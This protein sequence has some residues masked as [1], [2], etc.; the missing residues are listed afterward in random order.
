MLKRSPSEML[1]ALPTTEREA[2]VTSLNEDEASSLL[3]DWRGFVARPD[4]IAPDGNWDIWLCLAG[5]GW[6]KTRTGAEWIKECVEGGAERIALI[7]ETAA[8]ARDVIVEGESGILRCYPK[9]QRPL[10]E[11][12]KRRVTWQNGATATLF[13]A[14]E[15]DQLRG[16]QFSVAWCDELAKWRYARETWDMLQFGLRLGSHPRVLVTTT[17]RP[18]EVVKAILA[19]DEGAVTVTRG[20]TMDN[21]S[22]LAKTF[23]D[24]VFKRYQGTRLGRQELN[25]EI[26]GDIPNALWSYAMIETPRVAAVPALSRI[27]VAI[28]PAV[29]DNEGSDEHGI[30][31]VGLD[32]T[33][34]EAYVL[35]DGSKKGSPLDW[36]RR[37]VALYDHYQADAIVA[38]VNQG[39]DMVTQTIHT[40]RSNVKVISVRATR[41]KH[42]RAEPIAALY[43]QGKVHHVGSFPD[44]ERQM[45]MMTS[46][47]YEGDDSPDRLDA[48]V[49][50]CTELF[51]GMV[52][53]V[54]PLPE[55]ARPI[56]NYWNQ[57]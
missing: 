46:A 22:N 40:V 55:P 29:S 9:S 16:P 18:I 56:K 37:A 54:R 51:P 14:N 15:P 30:I 33:G 11:S 8:D 17:P 35:E 1:A 53:R 10:Y 20:N 13:N 6:G 57:M 27:V 36:A 19:G 42:V 26:L 21:R 44:L 41:G 52:Q 43:E 39:G 31:V 5:R 3:Y 50:A 4:Q 34:K 25:A 24:K 49:W 32:N 28:D 12:S 2:F 48:L 47:G 45:V 7:A 38:E 23:L